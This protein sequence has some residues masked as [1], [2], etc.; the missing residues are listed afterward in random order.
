VQSVKTIVTLVLLAAWLPATAHCLLELSGL[1][2]TD[3]CCANTSSPGHPHSN[4][5]DEACATLESG[6]C[7]L[8][9]SG[10]PLT[11]LPTEFWIS[12][13]VALHD[14]PVPT[15]SCFVSRAPSPPDLPVRWQ[16]LWRTALS[17]RAPSLAS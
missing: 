16:F 2:A 13:L 7:K 3:D 11:V 12:D 6:A 8:E 5:S 14:P 4:D 10:S 17:P 15:R 9:D 1:I